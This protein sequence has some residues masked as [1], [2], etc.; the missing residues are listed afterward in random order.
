MV[1]KELMT[2]T[3]EVVLDFLHWFDSYGELSQDHQ[4]FYASKIGAKAKTIYYKHQKIGMLA[5][6]PMVFC[7]AF[8][9][10]ARALFYPRMRLPIADAHFS[11]GYSLLFQITQNKEYYQRAVH[12][13]EVLMSTRCL[14]YEHYG[15]GYPFNWQ[16]QGGIMKAGTPLITTTPYCYEAFEYVYRIDGRNEWL[17]IMK[18]IADHVFL[19]YQDYET[20]PDAATCTYQPGKGEGVV[21]ASAYRAFTLVSAGL[22]FKNDDYLKAAERNINFVLQSQEENG[23]WPY[24]I[25]GTRDFID[26]FHTCFVLKALAKI[27]QLTGHDGCCSAIEKGIRYYIDNLFND[28]GFPKPF[29]K[30]PRFTVYKHELY[31]YAECIN[32]C[33]LLK[34]RFSELDRILDGVLMD[35]LSRWRKPDGSFRS[36]KLLLGWDNVPMHRWA[37]S[38]IFRSLCFFLNKVK[39]NPDS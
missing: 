24:A 25:K 22:E 9:P 32:L 33:V 39:D 29:S 31:D 21:N 27:E 13:L 15:W 36:R 5:V 2:R 11:M 12:F 34:G 30:A 23:S 19:D 7:E 10:S 37:Q 38:Q 3:H 8:I 14:G 26:H 20:G 17:D 16:T 28:V 18:S 1:D 4:D 6:L 35:V